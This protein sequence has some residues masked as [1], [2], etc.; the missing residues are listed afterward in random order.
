MRRGASVMARPLSCAGSTQVLAGRSIADV[1][2]SE[3]HLGGSRDA[4]V[5]AIDGTLAL[6][7]DRLSSA[8]PPVSNSGHYFQDDPEQDPYGFDRTE[9]ARPMARSFA[10]AKSNRRAA[11]PRG[12]ASRLTIFPICGPLMVAGKAC[13]SIFAGG[14]R[15]GK[16]GPIDGAIS[17]LAMLGRDRPLRAPQLAHIGAGV[18]QESKSARQQR[19]ARLREEFHE[20]M[21][22]EP[23]QKKQQPRHRLEEFRHA[24][25]EVKQLVMHTP[26]IARGINGASRNALIIT[27]TRDAGGGVSDQVERTER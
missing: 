7:R 17:A 23:Q 20:D 15:R 3:L 4:D 5:P 27:P 21:E 14:R 11:A 19:A 22:R 18:K 24:E 25:G 13:A 10:P 12:Q 9:H 16:A 2:V 26:P 1:I 8:K 6:G